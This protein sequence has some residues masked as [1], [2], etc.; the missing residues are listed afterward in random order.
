MRSLRSSLFFLGVS[1][2]YYRGSGREKNGPHAP[3]KGIRVQGYISRWRGV[4]NQ[5]ISRAR[6]AT[7]R[8]ASHSS[9]VAFLHLQTFG[10]PWCHLF[11]FPLPPWWAA[12]IWFSNFVR[13]HKPQADASFFIGS[14]AFLHTHSSLFVVP[15]F[16]CLSL[17]F[18]W[19]PSLLHLFYWVDFA[20]WVSVHF[21]AVS[22]FTTK[23]PVSNWNTVRE[24]R[25]SNGTAMPISCEFYILDTWYILH[26]ICCVCPHYSS[27]CLW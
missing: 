7:F 15:H 9:S 16:F 10:T 8:H 26:V 23:A 11:A 3:A 20:V 13:L 18:L 19:T 25:R 21:G 6:E 2:F 14:F 22:V 12:F 24:W 27:A 17:R 1:W 5:S 4:F